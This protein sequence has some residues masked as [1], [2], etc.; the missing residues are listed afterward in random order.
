M[1][2]IFNDSGEIIQEYGIYLKS[3]GMFVKT[4]WERAKQNSEKIKQLIDEGKIIEGADDIK[5]YKQDKN[6]IESI[7]ISIDDLITELAKPKVL[8]DDGTEDTTSISNIASGIIE[9]RDSITTNNKSLLQKLKDIDTKILDLQIKEKANN[10]E[11]QGDIETDSDK[12][13][14]EDTA[15][16]T[17]VEKTTKKSKTK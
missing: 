5:N 9:K 1:I 3:S 13:T 14:R 8:N 7:N 16:S 11:N 6:T 12:D 17:E 15:E 2:N 10:G 4:S